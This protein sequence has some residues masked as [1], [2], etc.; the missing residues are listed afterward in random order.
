MAHGVYCIASTF[1]NIFKIRTSVTKHDLGVK[2]LLFWLSDTKE[3]F[4]LTE[5]ALQN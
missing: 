3:E 2:Y 4:L 1:H 5:K